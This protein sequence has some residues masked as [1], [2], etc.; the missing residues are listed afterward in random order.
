MFSWAMNVALG[1][2]NGSVRHVAY[3]DPV[4]SDYRLLEVDE[5]LLSE[6]E[7]GT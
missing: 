1:L 3:A 5:Q 2:Q 6:M 4:R 7:T